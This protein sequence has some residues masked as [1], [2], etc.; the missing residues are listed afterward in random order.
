M[1]NFYDDNLDLKYYVDREIDWEPL[2]RLTEY[3]FRAEGGFTNSEEALEFFQGVLDLV[4][5]FA[6]NEIAPHAAAIDREHPWLDD[7]VVHFPPVL[8]GIF[9]QIKA[10]ELHGMCVPR[11]LGGMNCP[12]LL[13]V[14]SNELI[15][16]ADVSVTAHNGFHGGSAMAMLLYSILEGS[17]KFDPEQMA[18]TETRFAG[19]ISEIVAGEAWGSMDITEPGAGSDMAA[20]R[21][22]GEQDADGNWT[23]TGNK[24][25]ITSGHAKY[26]F[27]IARTEPDSGDDA[28]AGLQGMSMFLV[29]TYEIKAD[30]ERVKLASFDSLEEKLGHH[31]SATVAIS[32]DRTPAHLIGERGDGFKLMLQLMNNA[33]VV[34]G[35]EA[36]GI[37]EAAYRMACDYAAERESMGK[38]IDR[39]EMIADY[40]DEMRTDIQGI[41][42]LAVRATFHEE[43][44]QKLDLTLRF[45][46]PEDADDLARMESEKRR[47]QSTARR[48]TPLLKYLAAEKAVEIARRCI[49]IHGG[50][51]YSSEYGA[52]KLLRDAM[53]LPIYEGTSQIQSLMAMKD[54]LMG[55]LKNPKGFVERSAG[56]SWRARSSRDPLERRVAK[57]QVRSH[58]ALQFL[59]SRLAGHKFAT[60][61]KQP[62]GEWKSAF[63]E[64]D[65]K[66][67]F[68]LAMLHAERLTR[69]LTDVAICELLLEQSQRHPERTE[70]LQR[71]LER[72]EPRCRFLLDE[73][74]STGR[75]LLDVLRPA[76]EDS[77]AS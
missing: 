29:P 72:A 70:V 63:A 52:E 1:T 62:V 19:P 44:A 55:V 33:R 7:G 28:F 31:G 49:Q 35:F 65:P 18:I 69:I 56:A 8:D 27:V 42:A 51:G 66:Q 71:Y 57:L 6:A 38:T 54:N 37:C 12:F 47:H 21:T 3:D 14:L 22:R 36:L 9:D 39:H 50:Y 32:F 59:M 48:Y 4:G 43:M 13:F 68:A 46:P 73:I 15:A 23:V 60:V 61:R 17:T 10:L 53:V 58:R 75:R 67:D 26:H 16:R 2:V 11:E 74:T 64:W 34:V 45:M 40:L 20:L 24:I 30:G 41:R 25:F 77:Q 5:D 76:D